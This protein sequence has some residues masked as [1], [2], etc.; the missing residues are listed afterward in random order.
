MDALV[1]VI[2]PGSTST[3]VALFLGDTSI[4]SDTIYHDASQLEAC[5][6]V[7]DQ[8]PLRTLA[9]RSWTNRQLA[10]LRSGGRPAAL[11]AIAARGGLLRPLPSGTYLVDNAMLDDLRSP[12]TRQHAANLGAL[13]AASLCEEH[14]V[15]AFVTDPVSVDEM[16][17]VARVSGLPELPRIS[18]SHA[19]SMKHSARR[20]ANEVGIPY[21]DARLVVAHLGGGISVSAHVRGR[22]IDVNN[23]NDMGPF[24]PERVGTLPLTGLLDL[25]GSMP[26]DQLRRRL[27]GG[28]GL[29]AHLG[30]NDA[31]EVER[32]IQAGDKHADLVFQAMAYQVSKEIGAM[33]AAI[34]DQPDAIV[35]TGGLAY[36]ERFVDMVSRR[37]SF[38]ARVIVYPGGT[39]M[40]AL[41]GGARRVVSG[42]KRA[43]SYAEAVEQRNDEDQ[44]TEAR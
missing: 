36:S 10:A 8:L 9:V 21:S 31:R 37:V 15:S 40:E 29:V 17:D 12:H 24:S 22:M 27:W 3:K 34:G 1:L 32:R 28:G 19:L 35:L 4:A 26:R 13:I 5:P 25:A 33:C 38:I 7:I 16:D 20:A 44:S 18:F 43:R 2:N 30:T 11:T 39:E 6:R 42:A 14:G 23:A 41:A